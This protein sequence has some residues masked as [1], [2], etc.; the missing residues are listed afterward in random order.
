MDGYN[1]PLTFTNSKGC[2]AAGC[3][4]DLNA[5]CPPALA[6]YAADGSGRVVGCRSACAAF[7]S[8]QFCCTEAFG[9][10][11]AC[12]PTEFSRVF[13]TACPAAY[14]YAYDDLSSLFT[15]PGGGGGYVVT[16]CALERAV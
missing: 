6:V 2:P 10:P 5:A 4:G 7:G 16:F 12:V 13:K 9:S 14:S 11:Q 15:C 3:T 1:L 8:P